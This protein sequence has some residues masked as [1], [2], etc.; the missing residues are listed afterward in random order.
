M[1]GRCSSIGS[2]DCSNAPLHFGNLLEPDCYSALVVHRRNAFTE[3]LGSSDAG[4]TGLDPLPRPCSGVLF[5][6]SEQQSES[7]AGFAARFHWVAV[8][9]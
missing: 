1:V 9:G 4:K 3:A 2:V 7:V 8:D 5:H 6:C